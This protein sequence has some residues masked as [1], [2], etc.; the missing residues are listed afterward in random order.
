[1]VRECLL[2]ADQPVAVCQ[3][4]PA[5]VRVPARIGGGRRALGALHV[6]RH[7][8]ARGVALSGRTAV[9]AGRR[10]AGWGAPAR[11]PT[12]SA[13][14]ADRLRALPAAA[15]EPTCRASSAAPSA[16]SGTTWSARSSACRP[17]RPTTSACRTACSW[18]R[19]RS[20]CWT[21]S[22]PGAH[23]GE[24]RG[25]RGRLGGGARAR[26]TTAPTSASPT[27]RSAAAPARRPRA[28][29]ARRAPAAPPRPRA[30]YPP[31]AFRRDVE[32]IREHIAAGDIFQAVLS[33]RLEVAG[34][35]DPLLLYRYLRALNPAPYL[36]YLALDGLTLVGSSPE[37]LVRVEDDAVTVR[38]IAGTRPRGADA[39]SDAAL[40]AELAADAKERAEHLMLVDLGRNDV[41]RV[42]AFGSVAV[43]ELLGL[44]RYA[45]VQHLVSEVR[46]AR[47]R[48]R[49][50]GRPQGLLPGRDRLRRA[51][52]ARD[53]DPRRP[54]AHAPR[55]LRRRGRLHRL[56]RPGARHGHRDPDLL[57]LPDR[58]VVQAGAGIVA[59]SDPER[60]L[61]ETEAKARAA[62]RAI[63]LARGGAGFLRWRLP[64]RSG[65][66]RRPRSPIP[67]GRRFQAGQHRGRSIDRRQAGRHADRRP[68]RQQRRPDLRSHHLPPARPAERRGRRR[69]GEGPRLL[70]RHLPER[71]PRQRRARRPERRADLRQGR[72]LR[73]RA[74]QAGRAS[75]R[76]R[77]AVSRPPSRP[78]A[79]IVRQLPVGDGER[80]HPEPA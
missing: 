73:P 64:R 9:T 63:A 48:P 38:P 34:R 52:G 67:H 20:S 61:E 3:D 18:S 44:E 46:P 41:G 47:G 36:F 13:T 43:T 68:C 58:V 17:R 35:V 62:L 30:R 21:T 26:C 2:D 51:Q 6:P 12:R 72:V 7:R 40:A 69:A 42:A 24:R 50:G 11:S 53:G 31:E 80:G 27:T 59:D 57:V 76:R 79:T 29:R 10:D 65:I 28:P 75:P 39:A 5:A 56:G 60:E 77:R 4:R 70:Q 32:R 54:G 8:A 74:R 78:G 55:H 45:H 37:V 49:R 1:M 16:T 22:P 14:S 71:Q 33:R 66:F 19:T 15:R 25:A 23:R